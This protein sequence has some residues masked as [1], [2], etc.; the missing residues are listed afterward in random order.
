[1]KIMKE[2]TSELQA[3]MQ[4]DSIKELVENMRKANHDEIDD[5]IEEAETAIRE[6]VLSVELRSG[7][8]RPGETMTEPVEYR[9]LLVCGGPA[10]QIIGTLD[11]YGQAES[12][13]LE[14]QDW[15]T[16]WTKYW[17]DAEQEEIVLEFLRNFYFGE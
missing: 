4:F 16:P 6:S 15:G 3:K 10:V 13:S 17:R 1:M 8:G 14:H 11:K 5:D 12:C 9:I 2:N 7:W